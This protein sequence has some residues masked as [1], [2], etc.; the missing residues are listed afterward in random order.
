M[1]VLGWIPTQGWLLLCL[2]FFNQ[3]LPNEYPRTRV[4]VGNLGTHVNLSGEK[5]SG[6]RFSPKT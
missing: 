6:E 4:Q 2:F 3:W 5:V 1:N